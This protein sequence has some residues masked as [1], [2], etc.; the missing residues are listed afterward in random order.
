MDATDADVIVV[1]GGVIGTAVAW[2]AAAVNG[3]PGDGTPGAG[4]D[5]ILVDPG[6]ESSAASFVA[7]G[8]L[9]PV[10]ESVFGEEDLLALNLLAVDRFPGFVR[11]VEEA[12]GQRA[13]LRAEGTLT[14]AYDGG[15][16]AAL[17]RL[18][19]FRRGIGLS[20]ETVS[21]RECRRLEPFLA[22]GVAGGLLA[23][24]DLSVDNRRYLRALRAAAASAGVRT[25]RAT[26]TAIGEG[27]VTLTTGEVI[28]ATSVV[29]AAG[30]ATSQL[31]GVPDPVRK[32]IRPVKGQI[33]RLRHPGD[34]P[35]VATRTIRSLVA[36]HEVYLVPRADGEL[37]VGATQEERDD[38]DVTAGAV[39]DIL[40]D[41]TTVLP[42]AGEL[43][44]AEAS[45]GLRPGS[46]DNG[47]VVG[48]AAERLIVA[49]GH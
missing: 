40:R 8:M 49:A 6:D 5:V 34:L 35:P 31:D 9:A 12:S 42:A 41:A 25:V 4:R 1:G 38:T 36:G 14:V 23:A 22:S 18:A 19:E 24:G 48:R 37:V 21:G 32:A 10:S 27:T 13:G 29:A 46:T 47:P 28:T 30:W 16:L 7:A 39:G 44:L 2:R 20:A 17:N 15:D 3:T 45:A 43:V 33:L 11:R 26:A